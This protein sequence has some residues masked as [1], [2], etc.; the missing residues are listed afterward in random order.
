[1]EKIEFQLLLAEIT[2][3]VQVTQYMMEQTQTASFL[4]YFKETNGVLEPLTKEVKVMYSESSR[5][6]EGR[7]SVPLAALAPH[8]GLVMD[9]VE[10]TVRTNLTS[11]GNNLMAGLG[12]ARKAEDAQAEAGTAETDGQCEVKMTFR[13][14]EAADGKR[15][16]INMLNKTI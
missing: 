9:R 3:A 16:V 15:E 5:R 6:K 11:A 1:M 7:F 2:Q 13:R 14:E 8:N 12:S 10:V 4:D